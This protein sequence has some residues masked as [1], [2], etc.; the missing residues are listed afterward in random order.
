LRNFRAGGNFRL[1]Y[2]G[3]VMREEELRAIQLQYQ[4]PDR[5]VFEDAR[6]ESSAVYAQC[7]KFNWWAC[8]GSGE[9]SFPHPKRDALGRN[10]GQEYKLYSRIKEQSVGNSRCRLILWATERLKDIMANLRD[11]KSSLLWEVAGDVPELYLK[12]I[13]AEVKRETVR[14][15]SRLMHW[16]SYAKYRAKFYAR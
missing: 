1:L 15:W 10:I 13:D 14:S 8:M 2:F 3:M 6:Y 4:P 7:S 9:S 5:F 16:V 12:Q 11:G